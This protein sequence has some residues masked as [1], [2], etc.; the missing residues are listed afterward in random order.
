MY[1]DVRYIQELE[2]NVN[3]YLEFLRYSLNENLPVPTNIGRIKWQGLLAF[4]KEQAI[5][6][7]YARRILFANEQ[8]NECNWH[9]NKPDED[10]V[11]EWM[12]EVAKLRKRNHLLFE[13]SADLA[14]KFH[15]DG[16]SYCILKGQGN[17]LHY[18]MPDLRTSGD[19]DIW[20]WQQNKNGKSSREVI[21]NYVRKSFPNA[22]M[23]YL[24]IDY[25]IYNNVPVEVHIYPSILNNPFRNKKLQHYFNIQKETVTN[26]NVIYTAHKENF[27]FPT[28]T[29][30]FNR[31][32]ELCHIMH[33]EFDEGIGLRQLIDYFYLL[34]RGFTE[35]ERQQDCKL[36]SSFGM[37]RFASAV[38]YIMKTV[39]GLEDKYLL[40]R[41]DEKAGRLLLRDIIRGGNFGKYNKSFAHDGKKINPKRYFYKTFHNLSL[42]RYYPSETLWEML[43][44]TWHF[45]WRYQYEQF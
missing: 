6:G 42:V 33:H 7:I 23:M 31:I 17:A 14:K 43:F 12:G 35:E 38:M 18:P 2:M 21:D 5:V 8:L 44:R 39:L 25:P 13:K 11:M 3:I 19:I 9:G 34:R 4:A 1:G 20:V 27:T 26:H 40:M 41:P 16:F 30:S 37:F 36:L 28:P 24:H 29:D 32:F 22:K 15:K 45:F 10:E